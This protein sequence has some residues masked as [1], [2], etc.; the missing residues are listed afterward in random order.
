MSVVS[1]SLE[2]DRVGVSLA[3][4]DCERALVALAHEPTEGAGD[5]SLLG[6]WTTG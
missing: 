6:L 2:L 1:G 4:V 3:N 5:S